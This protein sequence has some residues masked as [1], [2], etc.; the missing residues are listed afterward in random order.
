LYDRYLTPLLAASIR[1]LGSNQVR[2]V[3]SRSRARR[4]DYNA[5]AEQV[6]LATD[7]AKMTKDLSLT[8]PGPGYRTFTLRGK[9]FDPHMPTE[10]VN[11]FA[12][13]HRYA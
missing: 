8:P 1:R 9:T 2:I 10:Y 3:F 11:S 13:R 12:I 5:I 6:S 4:F 7:T